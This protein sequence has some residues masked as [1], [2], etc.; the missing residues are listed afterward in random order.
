[1]IFMIITTIG[2]R[3]LYSPP[4]LFNNKS[5][6][7]FHALHCLHP[8]N[9]MRNMVAAKYRA[10]NK[11]PKASMN[12]RKFAHPKSTHDKTVRARALFNDFNIAC[13]SS[14][15]INMKN[16]HFICLQMARMKYLNACLLNNHFH[17]FYW[18][19]NQF[20]LIHT[21]RNNYLFIVQTIPFW[22]Y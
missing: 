2:W 19:R 13:Q 21:I 6:L 8:N 10:I 14:S 7:N 15:R 22:S 4:F 5:K 20:I 1:M 16:A 9:Y 17:Q 3:I 18:I 11:W 12:S